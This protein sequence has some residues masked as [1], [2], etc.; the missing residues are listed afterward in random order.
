MR[1]VGLI[2]TKLIKI[3]VLLTRFIGSLYLILKKFILFIAPWEM[4]Y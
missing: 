4:V 3:A 2:C 1:S